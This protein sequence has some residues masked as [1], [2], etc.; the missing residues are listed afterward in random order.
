MTVSN[1]VTSMLFN[2]I[3]YEA[4][5]NFLFERTESNLACCSSNSKTEKEKNFALL[6]CFLAFRWRYG[7]IDIFNFTA[8]SCM[9][10]GRWCFACRSP[11]HELLI[12]LG[13]RLVVLISMLGSHKT[14]ESHQRLARSLSDD[15]PR[16]LPTS[17]WRGKNADSGSLLLFEGGNAPH[18]PP[19]LRNSL[20]SRGSAT[21]FSS[22]L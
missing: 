20:V 17:T 21:C 18:H 13:L 1:D 14:G 6:I 16:E 15:F 19:L 22:F 4:F 12:V 3:S 2:N 10:P 7:L 8:R 5:K 9:S 11:S